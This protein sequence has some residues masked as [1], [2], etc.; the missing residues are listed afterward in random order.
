VS[1]NDALDGDL[2]KQMGAESG[3][4]PDMGGVSGAA[5][6]Y[7]FVGTTVRVGTAVGKPAAAIFIPEH[8]RGGLDAHHSPAARAGPRR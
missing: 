6:R 8:V 2:S 7:W 4:K 1:R 3:C 5:R